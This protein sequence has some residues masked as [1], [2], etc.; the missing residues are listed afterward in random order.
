MLTRSLDYFYTKH[1]II[2]DDLRVF[3]LSNLGFQVKIYNVASSILCR[4]KCAKHIYQGDM[5]C[6]I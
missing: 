3:K 6:M 4:Y 5:A 2:P 1:K